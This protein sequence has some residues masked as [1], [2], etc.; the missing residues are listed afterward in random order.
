[1]V[2]I[3]L[4]WKISDIMYLYINLFKTTV[5]AF[6]QAL[7]IVQPKAISV[8][9]YS[10]ENCSDMIIPE[11]CNPYLRKRSKLT[12][13]L[14]EFLAG[15]NFKGYSFY[16]CPIVY[17]LWYR[18]YYIYGNIC[19]VNLPACSHIGSLSIYS[20]YNLPNCMFGMNNIPRGAK[21]CI[22][23]IK[24]WFLALQ[25]LKLTSNV[26]HIFKVKLIIYIGATS[27]E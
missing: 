3:R 15:F 1:M 17:T 7:L 21:I 18:E 11:Y 19:S 2:Y 14:L 22:Q 10:S 25:Y 9:W 5:N 6:V 26:R 27:L 4:K 24:I 12:T 16:F 23:F 20:Y 8:L 13:I